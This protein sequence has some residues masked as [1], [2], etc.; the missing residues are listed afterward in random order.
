MT[1]RLLRLSSD[2]QVLATRPGN[3]TS[4]ASQTGLRRLRVRSNITPN[5]SF[6]PNLLRYSNGVAEKACHAVA[7]T[8]QVGLTQALGLMRQIA[9]ILILLASTLAPGQLAVYAHPYTIDNGTLCVSTTSYPGRDGLTIS[10]GGNRPIPLADQSQTNI[11]LKRSDLS[12]VQLAKDNKV[13][14]ST[15]FWFGDYDSDNVCLRYIPKI[16]SW[17]MSATAAGHNNCKCP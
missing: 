1:G 17:A 5:K 15:R 3:W 13:L 14:Y 7:S 16:K 8:A 2:G 9:C 10:I 11:T 4:A 6:K 12:T